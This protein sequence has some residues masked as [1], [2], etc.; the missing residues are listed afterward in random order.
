MKSPAQLLAIFARANRDN[1][2]SLARKYGVAATGSVIKRFLTIAGKGKRKQ[3]LSFF[4][5]ASGAR[6]LKIT[7]PAR[8]E[9]K[10]IR[11]KRSAKGVEAIARELRIPVEAAQVVHRARSLDRAREILRQTRSRQDWSP[12]RNISAPVTRAGRRES[13]G[14][15]AYNG[16]MASAIAFLRPPIPPHA[17]KIQVSGA[18]GES[19]ISQA[20]S[21]VPGESPPGTPEG[22]YWRSKIQRRIALPGI[23][24]AL[25]QMASGPVDI[26]VRWFSW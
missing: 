16:I 26:E 21:L 10:R 8:D 24:E 9:A 22:G 11:A 18:W 23:L 5:R 1:Y 6:A 15:I 12:R 20:R 3:A 19:D 4:Y 25:G 14:L 2:D 7:D 13:E 17:A